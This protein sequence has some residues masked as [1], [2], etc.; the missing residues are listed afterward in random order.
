[1][2]T[3]CILYIFVADDENG[4][5]RIE[6]E[7][8]AAAHTVNGHNAIVTNMENQQLIQRLLTPTSVPMYVISSADLETVVRRL[9]KEEN[10]RHDAERNARLIPTSAVMERL[11]VDATTLWRWRKT[12]RL[13][14]V[15]TGREVMFRE[16][17]ILNLME[18]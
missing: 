15:R 12:G 11:Q 14:G 7:G 6:S 13:K 17:D 4:D 18:G 9:I 3:P 8:V 1:M 2:E 16:Q 10:D 5:R